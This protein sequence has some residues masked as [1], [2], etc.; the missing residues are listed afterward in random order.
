VVPDIPDITWV[1]LGAPMGHIVRVFERL[2]VRFPVIGFY[3][4]FLLAPLYLFTS[5]VP[6]AALGRVTSRVQG[7]TVNAAFNLRTAIVMELV[8]KGDSRPSYFQGLGTSPSKLVAKDR[9]CIQGMHYRITALVVAV[10]KFS[11]R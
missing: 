9:Y 4:I 11:T 6:G 2:H 1:N 8:N 5:D 7:S 10:L 3:W